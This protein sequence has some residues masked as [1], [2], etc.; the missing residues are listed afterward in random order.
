[1]RWIPSREMV[2]DGLTKWQDNHILTQ[3]MMRGR[4]SLVDTPE[5]KRL[6]AEAT[7]RKR[8]YVQRAGVERS[9]VALAGMVFSDS[10]GGS[11]VHKSRA[12]PPSSIMYCY[13]YYSSLNTIAVVFLLSLLLFFVVVVRIFTPII[14]IP[15]SYFLSFTLSSAPTTFARFVGRGPFLWFP[16]SLRFDQ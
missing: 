3:V 8:R 13:H 4:W 12:L 7:E 2:S 10:H 5:A 16:K 14:D 1:M 6:R 9:L 15:L 11:S